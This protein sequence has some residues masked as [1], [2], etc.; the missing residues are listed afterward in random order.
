MGK[1][2]DYSSE[3]TANN[4]VIQPQPIKLLLPTPAGYKDADVKALIFLAIESNDTLRTEKAVANQ[5]AI[6]T[7]GLR[8]FNQPYI[9][10]QILAMNSSGVIARDKYW[11]IAKCDGLYKLIDPEEEKKLEL[12]RDLNNIPFDRST[13]FRND[14]NR[15]SI[16]GFKINLNSVALK[17]ITD[18]VRL[19]FNKLTYNHVFQL[20]THDNTIYILLDT[21][22]KLYLEAVK[23]L[24]HFLENE[25][26]I[27][28]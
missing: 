12:A 13:F 2:H 17:R 10:K 23:Q 21:S 7:N 9:S 1:R 6:I 3:K 15:G 8:H 27:R 24:N 22:S 19:F 26:I 11:F 20:I 25:F 28:K 5:I 18:D 4:T 14:P 16:F